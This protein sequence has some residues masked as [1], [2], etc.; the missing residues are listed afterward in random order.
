MADR[1]RWTRL[2]FSARWLCNSSVYLPL[3]CFS[4]SYLSRIAP[5]ISRF[6]SVSLLYNCSTQTAN[7]LLVNDSENTYNIQKLKRKLWAVSVLLV[8][9]QKCYNLCKKPEGQSHWSF[10]IMYKVLVQVMF[11]LER[12]S[13]RSALMWLGDNWW[14]FNSAWIKFVHF[15]TRIS[16]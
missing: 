5:K 14:T 7:I 16:K 12:A 4:H 13:V 6:I 10:S 8:C 11:T 9:V 3:L 1:V 2:H 15:K